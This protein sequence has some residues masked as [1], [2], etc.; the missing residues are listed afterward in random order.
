VSRFEYLSVLVSIVIALGITEVVNTWGRLLRQ[1][2]N[3]RFDWLHG[4]WTVFIVLML[5]QYWWGFWEFRVIEHWSF[6]GLLL[7]VTECLLL[8]LCALVLLPTLEAGPIDLRRHYLR[9]CRT[10]FAIG[11]VLLVQE[12]FV[13]RLVAGLPWLHP[14]N[15][16]RGA[17]VAVAAVAFR[18]PNVRVHATLGVLAAALL[19]VFVTSS[20]TR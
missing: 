16:I 17:G 15:A 7:V 19:A 8:V 5:I 10:F 3:V 2:A 12:A 13:D 6:A 14:E 9:Q 4:L 18:F 1:R 11:I 20:F